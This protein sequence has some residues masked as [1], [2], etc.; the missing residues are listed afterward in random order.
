[1]ERRGCIACTSPRKSCGIMATGTWQ[2]DRRNVRR[3]SRLQVTSLLPT[4]LS[5]RRHALR[6]LNCPSF[7]TFCILRI[8]LA[9]ELALLFSNDLPG[10]LVSP[11]ADK[12]D[13]AYVVRIRPFEEFAICY[14][15]GLHPNA[16]FHLWSSQS[17]T[18]SATLQ[19][20]QVCERTFP[21]D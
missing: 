7:G 17:L 21:N 14:E 11:Q 13:M 10:I 8:D 16:F 3:K 12:V 20:R 9:V 15:L 1:M 2:D 18:P 19:F 6:M 4:A 5:A